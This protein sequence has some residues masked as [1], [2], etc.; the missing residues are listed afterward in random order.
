MIKLTMLIGALM[1]GMGIAIIL[2]P[3]TMKKMISFWKEDKRLYAAGILRVVLGSIFLL[4][5]PQAD[6][7]PWFIYFF[8]VLIFFGAI[9]IFALGIDKVRKMLEYWDRKPRS[10][11]QFMG[12]FVLLLGL[13]VVY[14]AY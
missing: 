2:K 12:I 5:A 4:S 10:T 13:L 14:A 3:D 9:L 7:F 11:L 6:R 1:A 8:G